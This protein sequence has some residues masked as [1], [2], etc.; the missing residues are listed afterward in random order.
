MSDRTLDEICFMSVVN[1]SALDDDDIRRLYEIPAWER[2][3]R[4]KRFIDSGR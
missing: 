3:E 1:E 2:Y 4:A